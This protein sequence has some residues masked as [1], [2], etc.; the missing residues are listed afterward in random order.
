ML[1][2]DTMKRA[3]IVCLAFLSFQACS[4]PPPPVAP[5]AEPKIAEDLPTYCTGGEKPCKP[6]YEFTERL[7]RGSFPSAAL[8]LFQQKSPWQRRWIKAKGGALQFA[9]EVLLMAYEVPGKSETVEA[10]KTKGKKADAEL[11]VLRWDGSCASLKASE[12]VTFQ[13]GA[14]KHA[15]VDYEA[16]DTSV[17][18]SL[19][20][21]PDLEGAVKQWEVACDGGA[22]SECDK[23]H[24]TLSSLIVTKVRR[25][26][27]LSMPDARP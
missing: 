2:F 14:Q 23:A 19:L 26:L 17:Q 9:E 8:F 10:G 22:S 20:R 24:E 5:V 15:K 21:D 13:P 27:K 12:T 3:V 7:C 4:S 1:R 16:L 18:R 6:T 11:V 25:G